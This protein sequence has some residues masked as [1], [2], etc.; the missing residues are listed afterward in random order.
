MFAYLILLSNNRFVMH[1]NP[2]KITVSRMVILFFILANGIV[3]RQGFVS[4][5]AWYQLSNVT[6]TLFLLSVI[7][8]HRKTR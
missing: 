8:L 1:R 7:L 4:N 5:P 2:K 6:V 3:F